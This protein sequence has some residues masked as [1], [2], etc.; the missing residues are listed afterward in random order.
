MITL[1]ALGAA[2]FVIGLITFLY[3]LYKLFGGE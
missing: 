2:Y 1:L 3:G